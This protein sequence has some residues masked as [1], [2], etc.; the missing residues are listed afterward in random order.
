MCVAHGQNRT[1]AA[2]KFSSRCEKLA[3]LG[4]TDFLDRAGFE[5]KTE[6]KCYFHG[7]FHIFAFTVVWGRS[8]LWF[9][10]VPAQAWRRTPGLDS[11][12]SLW[13][14]PA[15]SIGLS[16]TRLKCGCK[17]W[18]RKMLFRSITSRTA[19]RSTTNSCRTI[20]YLYS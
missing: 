14:R 3:D 6:P 18:Q 8:W 4:L 16:L 9:S 19:I 12:L 2:E 15:A 11:R 1:P 5:I 10:V 7:W 17:S 20:S 13:P